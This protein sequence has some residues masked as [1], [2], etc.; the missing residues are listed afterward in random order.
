[1]FVNLSWGVKIFIGLAPGWTIFL[2]ISKER[3]DGQ[4]WLT[5]LESFWHL[6]NF[7]CNLSKSDWAFSKAWNNSINLRINIQVYLIGRHGPVG[8]FV[9]KLTTVPREDKFLVSTLTCYGWM[10]NVGT[11]K[12][13][14][15]LCQ[16]YLVMCGWY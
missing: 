3:Q 16:L 5:L 13:D 2:K 10:E 14:K 15:S 9:K 7:S 12:E 6:S 4:N 11:K 1:M 8:L